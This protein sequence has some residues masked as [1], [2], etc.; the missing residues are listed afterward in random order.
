MEGF[1]GFSPRILLVENTDSA[2]DGFLECFEREGYTVKWSSVGLDVFNLVAEF[3]P[4]L[5]VV[6]WNSSSPKILE[7]CQ[8]IRSNHS[9]NEMRMLIITKKFQDNDAVRILTVGADDYIARPISEQELLARVWAHLR[10]LRSKSLF[11]NNKKKGP[12][13]ALVSSLIDNMNSTERLSFN[14][15]EL[16]IRTREVKRHGHTIKISD[17]EFRLLAILLQNPKK[18][19]SRNE[20]IYSLWEQPDKIDFRTIDVMIGRLRKAISVPN[21]IDAIRSV[22][23]MGY[24]LNPEDPF[25]DGKDDLLRVSLEKGSAHHQHI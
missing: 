20:I 9:F 16:D 4:N 18:I 2:A 11:A 24:G 14:G 7:F 13:S 8:N 15:I 25:I 3:L 22:R 1:V 21:R 23:G 5:I 12:R 19:F 6:N 17:A 10:P